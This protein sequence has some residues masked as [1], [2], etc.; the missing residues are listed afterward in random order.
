VNADTDTA[1]PAADIVAALREC[2][3]VIGPHDTLVVRVPWALTPEQY[4]QYAEDLYEHVEFLGLIGRVLL[5]PAEQVAVIAD[6][7]DG[8]R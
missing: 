1:V 6:S 8:D 3:T 7:Q 4:S 2:V 5:L